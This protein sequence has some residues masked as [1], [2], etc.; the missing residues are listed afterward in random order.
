MTISYY[1]P[2]AIAAIN[3]Y[4]HQKGVGGMIQ[5]DLRGLSRDPTPREVGEFLGAKQGDMWETVRVSE[6]G[7]WNHYRMFS[8]P[9]TIE[10]RG[11]S[12]VVLDP[13]YGWIWPVQFRRFLK[14][15][16]VLEGVL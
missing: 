9:Q 14:E 3:F 12:G 7:H 4:P 8:D 13:Q 5:V 15:E 1:Y 6:F 11:G 2:N 10:D 16:Y